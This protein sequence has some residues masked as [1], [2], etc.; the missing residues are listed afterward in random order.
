MWWDIY[1]TSGQTN[2]WQK[3][4]SPTHMDIRIPYTFWAAPSPSKLPLPMGDLDPH[5]IHGSLD[6]P[7]PETQRVSRSIQPM[8]GLQSW[9][10]YTDRKTDHATPSATIGLSQI[11]EYSTA[12]RPNKTYTSSLL[13]SVK[14]KKCG[15][16]SVM[17]KSIV[18]HNVVFRHW[19]KLGKAITTF[20]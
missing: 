19:S 18:T 14:V 3:A 11:Y 8:Q 12:M 15:N 17:D 1:L 4:A 6:P 5:L 13:V 20:Y 10:T 9:Q 7:S 2:I 16:R